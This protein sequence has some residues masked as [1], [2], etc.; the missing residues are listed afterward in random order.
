MTDP[1]PEQTPMDRLRDIGLLPPD[2]PRNDLRQI[3]AD[4]VQEVQARLEKLEDDRRVEQR[5]F[6]RRQPRDRP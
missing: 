6:R 2:T 5:R 1:A 3:V 4:A